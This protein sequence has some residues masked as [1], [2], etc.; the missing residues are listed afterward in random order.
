MFT[1]GNRMSRKY[2]V[3]V[4]FL[5]LSLAACKPFSNSSRVPAVQSS[6][7]P[8]PTPSPISGVTLDQAKNAN[9]C[10]VLSGTLELQLLV[11]PAEAV[12][13]EPFTVGEIPFA[14][15]NA[16]EPYIIDGAN[17]IS[18]ENI[19]EEE[20]GTY[21]VSFN[22]DVM[23]DGLC[24]GIEGAEHLLVDVSMN[25]D[26]M[27][28]VEAEGFHGEYPWSGIN[29]IELNLPLQEGATAQGEGWQFV[30]HFH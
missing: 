23:L 22:M 3:V 29:E 13:L 11:G 27:V 21:T 14:V 16:E 9:Q 17:L 7:V 26:Q 6:P 8:T 2:W 12:G 19:L 5:L 4:L 30:L 25:G 15:V 24:T 18:Y 10:K 20:W 1:G 28:E